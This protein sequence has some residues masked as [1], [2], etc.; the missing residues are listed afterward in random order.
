LERETLNRAVPEIPTTLGWQI[1]HTP[2]PG[3][4][5]DF[6]ALTRAD[7][8]VLLLGSDIHAPVGLE[9]AARR[10]TGGATHAFRDG[11]ALQTQAA[12]AFFRESG[13]SLQWRVYNDVHALRKVVLSLLCGHILASARQLAIGSDEAEK[14][15]KFAAGL[16]TSRLIDEDRTERVADGA[17]ILSTER[18]EPSTGVLL[19]PN[20][21]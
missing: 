3:N 8:H 15:A 6:A 14:I 18:F 1:V 19:K 21:K 11:D 20:G 9:W 17:I 10:R 5:P 12:A 2:R 16:D 13:S 7:V 4:D